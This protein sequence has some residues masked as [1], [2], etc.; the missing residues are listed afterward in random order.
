MMGIWTHGSRE[1]PSHG[2]GNCG[3][4]LIRMCQIKSSEME[5]WLFREIAGL[6][7][8]YQTNSNCQVKF[9]VTVALADY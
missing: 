9:R 4:K 2:I 6:S 1:N 5:F 7:D 8:S 3:V